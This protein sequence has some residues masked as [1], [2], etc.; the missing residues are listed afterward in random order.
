MLFPTHSTAILLA[1]QGERQS[2]AE[3]ER[4]SGRRLVNAYS[5]RR[6]WKEYPRLD[7]KRLFCVF[8]GTASPGEPLRSALCS[9]FP[10]TRFGQLFAKSGD[11][12]L[13][14]C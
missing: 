13:L 7:D 6:L 5:I 2:R 3:N 10:L 8:P 9:M 4:H 12:L 14:S 11:Y 1:R